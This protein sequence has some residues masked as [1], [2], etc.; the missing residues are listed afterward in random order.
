[1]RRSLDLSWPAKKPGK[2]KFLQEFKKQLATS[3]DYA[4]VQKLN[5]RTVHQN[6][7]PK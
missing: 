1:M 4:D 2:E 3:P 6:A 5:L 7:L